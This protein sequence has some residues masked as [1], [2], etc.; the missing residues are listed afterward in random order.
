MNKPFLHYILTGIIFSILWSSASIAGKFGLL[1]VEP[2]VLFTVRF[3]LAGVVMLLYAHG[4]KKSR[5]PSG[6]EWKH[7]II[8]GAFNTALY[9]GIFIIALQYIT[10]GLTVLAIALNPL[11]ISLM[12]S[13]WSKAKVSA[14]V[15]LSIALGIAGVFIASYPLLNAQ[16][17]TTAGLLLLALSMVAYSFGSV[18]YS[19][20][21]WHLDRVTINGWQVLIGGILIMPFAFLFHSQHNQLDLRFW[22]SLMWLVV[23]VSIMA[24]QLWLILL[25]EDA[26]RASFW[27]YLCPIFGL[28][29]SAILLAEP[30]SWYTFFGTVLVLGALFMGQRKKLSLKRGN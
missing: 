19:S 9:L 12:T 2:L 3:I 15:W 29:F 13:I 25:K 16:E 1:S 24:V 20:V 10:A 21:K 4:L 23:P 11:F 5:I 22:L 6:K 8:F 26:I 14:A 18:Y 28:I 17:M 7:L 30:L 27:L